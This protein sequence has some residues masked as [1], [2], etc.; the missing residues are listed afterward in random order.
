MTHDH[1]FVVIGG[2]LCGLTAAWTLRDRDV[3]LLE[4]GDRVGGRI[5]SYQRP[6]YWLN[7]GAHLLPGPGSVV[8]GIVAELGL[9]AVPV[10]GTLRGLALDGSVADSDR[11]HL[12]PL[13]LPLGLRD[14][15]SFARA[16]LRLQRGVRRYFVEGPQLTTAPGNRPHVVNPEFLDDERFDRFLGKMTP[17]VESIFRCAV[18]RGPSTLEEISAGGGIGLFAHVWGGRRTI[19][20]RNLLGGTGELPRSLHER[21][22][23]LIRLSSAAT[24]VDASSE[25]VTVTLETGEA[26]RAAHAIVCVP[27]PLTHRL[28][29]DLPPA[30]DAALR[31]I[32]YRP[33]LSMA[34]LTADRAKTPWDDV[35]SV[36][37]PGLAFDMLFNHAMP[38]R[39][40]VPRAPGGSIM[41]YAGA[42]NAERLL[43]RSDDE[44]RTLFLRDIARVYPA[45]PP[46]VAETIVQRWAIGNCVPLPGRGA[47]QRALESHATLDGR[48]HLAGDYFTPIGTMETSATT[49]MLAA[50]RA[51]SA[52]V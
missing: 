37:T 32:T 2:G 11:P 1:E 13:T 47:H 16:G 31:S 4:A 33:F 10:T 26:I 49:G 3:V 18:H 22:S 28:L 30:L 38:L 25:G 6:P 35:Y 34:M 44:I 14:R 43:E 5:L 27:A 40:S 12:Y 36:A 29:R 51:L 24:R 9:T 52:A 48:I 20:A 45:L 7:L 42:A 21:L 46:L 50:R 23:A 15:I 41:V 17:N 8:D 19:T 39:P